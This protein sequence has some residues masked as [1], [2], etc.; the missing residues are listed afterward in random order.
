MKS[1]L[2]IAKHSIIASILLCAINAIIINSPV[3]AAKEPVTLRV[4]TY[5]ILLGGDLKNQAKIKK[6]VDQLG[7]DIIAYQEVYTQEKDGIDVLKNLSSPM[8]KTLLRAKA[9]P[10]G[11]R[12]GYGTGAISKFKAV[13]T[14]VTKVLPEGEE[15][16]VLGYMEFKIQGKTIG[17]Y[18]V[19]ASWITR[20]AALFC[21]DQQFEHILAT[22]KKGSAEY[23]IIAGDFNIEDYDDYK[24]FVN[25]GFKLANTR[26]TPFETFRWNQYDQSYKNID[27]IMVTSNIDILDP[28]MVDIALSDHNLFYADLRLN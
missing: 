21:R 12:A 19:H 17:V 15:Q 7:I 1:C 20:G 8:T 2:K 22:V 6:L 3:L 5:N 23:K 18:T 28:A 25:A 13:K 24:P 27:N 9:L 11:D 4:G 14:A 16:R 26:E 10:D